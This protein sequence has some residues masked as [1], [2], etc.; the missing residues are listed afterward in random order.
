MTLS[1]RKGAQGVL[2]SQMLEEAIKEGIIY[3]EYGDIGS[4]S[5]QPASI[6]LHLGDVAH[7]LRC[8]FLSESE[9]VE[10]KL[11]LYRMGDVDLSGDGGILEQNRPYL[12]PLQER[13]D[14][15]K[16]LRAKANPKSSTG[17]LDIFTRII[18]D[19][20]YKF[21][22][23]PAQHRGKLYLEVV[24]RTFTIRVHSGLALNQLR[25]TSG[26]A[27]VGD[28][29][30]MQ[31]YSRNP[32]LYDGPQPI[33]S[34]RVAVQNGIFLSAGLGTRRGGKPVGYRARENSQLIDLSRTHYYHPGPFWETVVNEHGGRVVLE[35]EKFYL[36]LSREGV[37][38]PPDYAAE[39]IAFDE[40]IAELRT[41]YAGFFDPG[42][43]FGHNS[44]GSRAAM[45]VRARDVAFSVETGQKLSKLKLERMLE[46]PDR[47]YGRDIGSNYQSQESALSK[48]FKL[49][50]SGYQDSTSLI[51]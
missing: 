45:E 30:L 33:P 49:R 3:K 42:F 22:E 9:S 35:R 19:H 2:P 1:L 39:M 26:D 32:L 36:L 50:S 13:V 51:I 16:A 20:S 8:S 28:H 17:R 43:G 37:C 15:P 24:S 34:R 48:H 29:E 21:D 14:L 18:T 46:V 23:L 41:H 25:L 7:R 44:H 38:I 12:I 31:I 11:A 6:D 10:R 4:E 47:Q 27:S 5:I 40:T